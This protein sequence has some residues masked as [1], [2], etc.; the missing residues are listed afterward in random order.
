M[1]VEL[2]INEARGPLMKVKEN[3]SRLNEEIKITTSDFWR[4]KNDGQ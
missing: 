1:A 2:E 4:L 3:I